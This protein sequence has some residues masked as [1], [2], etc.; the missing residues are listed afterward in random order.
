[1]ACLRPVPAARHTSPATF[2]HKDLHNCT[3][4]FLRQDATSRALEPPYSGPHK[5]LSRREK[6]CGKPLTVST[7][8]V[9][10][11]Y[12]FNEADFRLI[13]Y[14]TLLMPH[15]LHCY[16]FNSIVL[17][18]HCT[19][20]TVFPQLPLVQLYCVTAHWLTALN[21]LYS[22]SCHL[23]NSVYYFSLTHSFRSGQSESE[24]ELLYN[25]RS[26]SQSVLVSSPIWDFWPEIYIFFF[27]VSYSLVF[28]APSLTRGRVCHLSV[29]SQSTVVSQYL[30][31]IFT[32][33]VIHIW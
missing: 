11:A 1:M 13:L 29:Y 14:T 9:K 15:V 3:H 2:V 5:V 31:K 28:G 8:R 22:L 25:W 6:T 23:F 7:D 10:P 30:H 27:F 19:E 24:S 21:W 32:Y 26:V 20:L 16:L 18:T 33:C 4:V 12:I 17:L